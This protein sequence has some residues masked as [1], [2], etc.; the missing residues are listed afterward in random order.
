M[1]LMECKNELHVHPN[2]L[3]HG[4]DTTEQDFRNTDKENPFLNVFDRDWLE[5]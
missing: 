4:K 2:I 5:G 1:L 3:K